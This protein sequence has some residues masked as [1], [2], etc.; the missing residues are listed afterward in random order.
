[1]TMVRIQFFYRRDT[2]QID[3]VYVNCMTQS[4]VLRDPKKYV[5]VHVV[6]PP[7]EVTRNHRVVL[8]DEG[9]VLTTTPHINPV[10]PEPERPRPLPEITLRS[11]DGSAWTVTI[12]NMGKIRSKKAK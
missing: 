2:L 8:D 4:M 9:E 12:D 10:Q 3:A 6:D 11:P 7:Y 5:E 1:M